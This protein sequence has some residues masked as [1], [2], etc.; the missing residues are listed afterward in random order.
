M[1]RRLFFI[2]VATELLGAFVEADALQGF[3]F[4]PIREL[5]L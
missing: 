4:N 1:V 5:R 3:G 2:L